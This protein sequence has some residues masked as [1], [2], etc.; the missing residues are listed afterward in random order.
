MTEIKLNSFGALSTTCFGLEEKRE[1]SIN[2]LLTANQMCDSE[3][4]EKVIWPD[5]RSLL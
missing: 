4:Q 5:Y 2:H 3:L 1:V